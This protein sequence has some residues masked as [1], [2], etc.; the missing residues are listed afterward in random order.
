MIKLFRLSLIIFFTLQGFSAETPESFLNKV[1]QNYEGINSLELKMN[2]SLYKSHNSLD[3]YSFDQSVFLMYGT[4]TYRTVEDF[5]LLTSDEFNLKIDNKEQ[6]IFISNAVPAQIL[7]YKID[8]LL[9]FCEKLYVQDINGEKYIEL[10]IKDEINLPFSKIKLIV[11]KDYL[12]SQM[13]FYYSTKMDFSKD[14]FSKEES[15]PKLVVDYTYFKKGWRDK[16]NILSTANYINQSN[17]VI[18]GIGKYSNYEVIDL[19]SN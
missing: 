8:V 5:E 3:K 11:T 12:I 15:L 6:R 4:N 2:Y 7:D 19:R 17:Q 9:T 14:F 18:A 16:D 1:R 10:L 13:T